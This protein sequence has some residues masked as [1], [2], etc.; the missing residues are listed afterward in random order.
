[1]TIGDI[2]IKA[3]NDLVAELDGE[4]IAVRC[5]VREWKEQLDLFENAVNSSPSRSVDIVIANAGLGGAGD[6]MMVEQ[7]RKSDHFE[8]GNS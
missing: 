1:M 7:G 6:P 2:D 8:Q 5:D 4:A 3:A